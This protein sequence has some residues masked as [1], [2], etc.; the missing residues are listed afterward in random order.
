M[1]HPIFDIETSYFTENLNRALEVALDDATKFRSEFITP[2]HLL[3]AISYQTAFMSFCEM[4]DVNIEEMHNELFGYIISIDSVPEDEEYIPMMSANLNEIVQRMQLYAISKT[5]KNLKAL[6]LTK[7]TDDVLKHGTILEAIYMLSELKHSMAQYV[8][9]KYI[10]FKDNWFHDINSFYENFKD[11][12]EAESADIEDETENETMEISKPQVMAEAYINGKRV[13]LSGTAIYDKL[14]ASANRL[15][16][17][18]QSIEMHK[19]SE[20]QGQAQQQNRHQGQHEPS[21]TRAHH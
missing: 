15:L 5:K 9:N 8:L 2:E 1:K 4:T 13:D 21:G 10:S 17:S 19:Q 11:V 20:S 3:Y 14:M 6:G 12:S 7:M 16:G 18:L